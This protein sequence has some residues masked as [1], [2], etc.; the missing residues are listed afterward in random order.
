ML[1]NGKEKLIE[2]TARISADGRII[3]TYNP[4]SSPQGH[5]VFLRVGQ[6][7][8]RSHPENN[9]VS[10]HFAPGPESRYLYSSIG[11]ITSQGKPVG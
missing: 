11:L 4:G 8:K 6:E 9:E 3:T 7:F 2:S 1:G 5:N 10:G